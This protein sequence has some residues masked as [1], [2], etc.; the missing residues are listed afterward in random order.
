[1]SIFNNKRDDLLT[2]H[3]MSNEKRSEVWMHF[4]IVGDN[5]AK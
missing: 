4:T 1:M 5:K 3:T 2:K